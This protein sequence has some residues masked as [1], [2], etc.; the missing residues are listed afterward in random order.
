MFHAMHVTSILF[1]LFFHQAI[2]AQDK[3]NKGTEFW[4]GYGHNSLFTRYEPPLGINS[5]THILY[6]S[7]EQAAN[8][9]VSVN[10][11]S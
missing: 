10:G 11:T 7:S 4:L 1:F 9:T 2:N 5:Q 8:V 3:S 6:I